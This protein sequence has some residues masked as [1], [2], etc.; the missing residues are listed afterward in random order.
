MENNYEYQKEANIAC[1]LEDTEYLER[2]E[3]LF[4]VALEFGKAN[5]NWGLHVL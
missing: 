5:I 2:K 4:K 1:L 3:A